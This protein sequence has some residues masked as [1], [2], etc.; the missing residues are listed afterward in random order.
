MMGCGRDVVGKRVGSISCFDRPS[1]RTSDTEMPLDE[2]P[3]SSASILD[4]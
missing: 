4:R 3:R 1:S 2:R